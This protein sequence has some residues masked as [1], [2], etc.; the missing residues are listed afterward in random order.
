MSNKA[1]RIEIGSTI[2]V[3]VDLLKDRV[4]FALIDQIEK[5]PTGEVVEYKMTDGGGIGFVIKFSDGTLNWFF[6]EEVDL[7][8]GIQEKGINQKEASREKNKDKK[9]IELKFPGN[10]EQNV[11]IDMSQL[12]D[13][14]PDKLIKTLRKD[15][16]GKFLDYK[17][18]DGGGIG[19]VVEL[20]DGSK[21]WFFEDELRCRDNSIY[22]TGSTI[23]KSNK[24]PDQNI[25]QG[26]EIN[27]EIT[28]LLNP[29]NFIQWL[30]YSLKDVV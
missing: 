21:N 29:M 15:G 26:P 9:K 6:E 30:M 25:F 23:S 16:R 17:M 4:P 27:G 18:T 22:L 24:F 11:N 1:S 7:I 13:Q 2:K 5:D 28:E 20:N 8:Q 3:E 19:I 12:S 10:L 14:L